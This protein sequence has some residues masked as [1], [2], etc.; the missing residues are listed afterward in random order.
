MDPDPEQNPTQTEP[1]R[2]ISK[3]A[4]DANQTPRTPTTTRQPPIEPIRFKARRRKCWQNHA[5]LTLLPQLTPLG[6]PGHQHTKRG[7]Y[8]HLRLHKP[9]Y[10][11][12]ASTQTSSPV[13]NIPNQTPPSVNRPAN[14]TCGQSHSSDNTSLDLTRPPPYFTLTFLKATPNLPLQQIRKKKKQDRHLKLP[15][16]K[17]GCWSPARR[18]HSLSL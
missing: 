4:A 8:I 1:P 15:S 12:V 17:P 6:R 9:L 10:S 5:T 16:P 14:P 3:T 18:D 13:D 11:M 2:S 7:R